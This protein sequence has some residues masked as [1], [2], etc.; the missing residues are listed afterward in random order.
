MMNSLEIL[1]KK[2]QLKQRAYEMIENCKVEIRNFNQ[3]ELDEYNAIK[4]EIA[5]LNEELRNLDTALSSSTDTNNFNNTKTTFQ[6]RDGN[7]VQKLDFDLIETTTEDNKI[8]FEI[9]SNQMKWY[10]NFKLEIPTWYKGI[11]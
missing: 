6:L 10:G 3:T 7:T 9:D 1:D 11:L 5:T 2:A 8:A 4:N